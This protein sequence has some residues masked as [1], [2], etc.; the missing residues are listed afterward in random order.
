MYLVSFSNDDEL[1]RTV[2]VEPSQRLALAATVQYQDHRS[3]E[4]HIAL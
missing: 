1:N 2:S 3:A 4:E